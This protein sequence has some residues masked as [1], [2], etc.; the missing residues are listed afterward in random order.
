MTSERI[1]LGT[2]AQVRAAKA[3]DTEELLALAAQRAPNP[4]IFDQY[5]PAFWQARASSNRLDFYHT[6][7]R[8]GRNKTLGN[9]KRGLDAGVSYLDS[10]NN[11]QNGLGQS[12]RGQLVKTDETDPET[13]KPIEEVWG[14]FFTLQ[15]VEINGHRSD[16]FLALIGSG[17][18][19]DVSVGFF[20]RDIE[21]G[22]CGKQVFDW[23]ADDGCPHLPGLEYE[24]EGETRTAWAWINDGELSEVSQ[25]YDGASPGAAVVKAEQMGAEGRLNDRTRTQIERRYNTRIALPERSYRLGGIPL[26]GDREERGMPDE[27]NTTIRT[28]DALEAVAEDEE[29]RIEE[30]AD[31]DEPEEPVEAPEGG[32]DSETTI[33][34]PESEAPEPEE[35]ESDRMAALRSR[36]APQGIRLGSDPVKAVR[37]LAEALLT[38]RGKITELEGEAEIGKRYKRDLIE[39]TLAAGVR[40][41]GERFRRETYQRIL[42][43]LDI[44]SIRAIGEDFGTEGD[45]LFPGGRRTSETEEEPPARPHHT[46]EIDDPGAFRA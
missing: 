41:R 22:L 36:Y 23:W 5:P 35:P 16:S 18:W 13:G 24:W 28:A 27:H 26:I 30:P 43:G 44:D 12:L 37:A 42:E 1:H 3:L 2:R 39:A 4:D 45:T 10:H 34:E 25:V 17:V 33:E 7:M 31:G 9:F 32:D 6:R 38:A 11:R 21:C 14:D 15:G 46:D 19:R 8:P 29:T 20:A 40:A